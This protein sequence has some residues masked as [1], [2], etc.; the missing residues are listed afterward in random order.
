MNN[1][2]LAPA[3][4]L[5]SIAKSYDSNSS[6]NLCTHK[7]GIKSQTKVK[8]GGQNI[9]EHS[10]TAAA[11]IICKHTEFSECIVTAFDGQF[12]VWCKT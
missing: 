10:L 6:I 1:Q 12:S 8:K 9:E 5:H 4:D 7:R 3:V 2:S 11:P